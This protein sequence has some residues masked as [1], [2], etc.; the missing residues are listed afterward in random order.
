MAMICGN[1]SRLLKNF[2]TMHPIKYLIPIALALTLLVSSCKPAANLQQG[3]IKPLPASFGDTRDTSNIAAISWKQYFSD[4]HLVRLLDTALAN[5]PDLLMAYQRIQAAQADVLL[6][7]GALRPALSAG[8]AA[9]IRR[10][11]AY[12]MDGAGNKTT[13]IQDDQIVPNHLPDYFVGLQASW[14]IDLWGKLRSRRKAAMARFLSSVEG[15]NWV[16]THL[17]A[18]LALSYYELL[19]LDEE[20]NIIRETIALQENALA[21]VKVQKQAAAANELA[22]EQFEAQ[23]LTLR[24]MGLEVQQA[25]AENESRLNFLAGSYPQPIPRDKSAFTQAFPFPLQVGVPGALLQNRP[26]IKQAE[27]E[28]TA[29]RADVQAARA[30]FYPSLN[31][32][33]SMGMQA[34]KTS[35]LLATPESFAYS[36]L[37]NLTAPLLNRSGV[38]AAFQGANASQSA[39][40]QAYRKTLL[41]AYMEVYQQML[42]MNNLQQVYELKTREVD[43]F[44]RSNQTSSELFKTGRANYLEVL[45]TQQNT[46]QARL[47]LIHTR[48][49]QF[50]TAVNLY[51]ALG[52]GWR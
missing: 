7:R 38:R 28:L 21:M 13:E 14:E 15:R 39:A 10:F 2:N 34:F 33:G 46:L 48:K 37:G 30:A 23:L 22:V 29:A 31:I 52:G 32:N 4:P 42:R 20:L 25:I 26:D 24:S 41:T 27:L 35:L 50:Q 16:I 19:A 40:L 9:G 47:A 44:T 8:G 36:L 45:I 3:R 6:N 1:K 12:T 51:K 5:N 43:I 11:G 17:V 18:E 49:N